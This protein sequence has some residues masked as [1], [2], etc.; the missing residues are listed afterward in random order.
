MAH[1]LADE[2]NKEK[3]DPKCHEIATGEKRIKATN[4]NLA[5]SLNKESENAKNRE[6]VTGETTNGIHDASNVEKD[7]SL[8]SGNVNGDNREEAMK[9][10]KTVASTKSTDMIRTEEVSSH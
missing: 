6:N 8:C 3:E 2:L 7:N 5:E 4:F 10:K 1:T 9:K